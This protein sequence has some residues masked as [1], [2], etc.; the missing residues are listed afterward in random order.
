MAGVVMLVHDPDLFLETVL[1][2]YFNHTKFSSFQVRVSA[3]AS[4]CLEYELTCGWP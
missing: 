4:M 2:K 1:P 3:R